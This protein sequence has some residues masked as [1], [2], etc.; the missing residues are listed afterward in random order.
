MSTAPSIDRP[1]HAW[2]LLA[3]APALALAA[4]QAAWPWPFFSDD[5]FISLRYA[6]RLLAGEGLTWT[7]G[8][9]VE[10]YSNLLWVLGCAGLGALGL[11]LVTAAR[12]LGALCTAAALWCLARA[13]G[14]RDL[15]TSLCA[16]AAPLLVAS[17][18]PVLVWT[19]GGLEGPMV[20]WLLAWG[21]G[22]VVRAL[23]VE[24]AP[25]RPA[26]LLRLGAP[27]ALLCV[28]RP[29]GAL[30]AFSTGV[31]LG[32]CALRSGWR[33]AVTRAACFGLWPLVAFGAQLAFRLAYYGDWVPNTAH[34]KAEFD[35]GGAAGL[36]Y[37]GGAM[38]VLQGLSWPALFAA[39]ALLAR[40]A[41]RCVVPVLAVPLGAWLGYLAAIG[42]DH[43][44]GLRL[45]HGALVPMALLAGAGLRT[46][47]RSAFGAAVGLAL[48][49]GGVVTNVYF[50]RTDGRSHEA[51]GELWEWRGRVLGEVLAAAFERQQPRLAVDAAGALPYYAKLPALDMLG[52]CDRTIATTPSPAWLHTVRPGTPLPPGHLRGN[53]RYVM[54]RAP[55]LMLFA[56]PPGLPLPV[57]VS[58]AEFED[59]PRFLD[60]YRCVLLELGEREVLPGRA[61]ALVSP[62]WVRIEGR[63]GVQRS[64]QRIEIPPW[65]FG[66]YALPEPLQRRHQPPTGDAAAEARRAAH[67]A[68][69]GAWYAARAAVAV[70]TDAGPLSL[71]L[72]TREPAR[73]TMQVPGGV[74]RCELQAEP[75]AVAGAPDLAAG[76]A[77]GSFVVPAPGHAV[78]LRV[79]AAAEA[80]LPVRVR[81]VVLV[82]SD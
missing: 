75:A 18:Q 59:D 47:G 67:V 50:A 79:Q 52:L 37:V 6:A 42:G 76:P 48:A 27:F 21:F 1:N 51:R 26:R 34:V 9:R 36:A 30:W 49:A 16:A 45:V 5:S 81:S 78:D 71:E 38:W 72:R 4:V 13:A 11:E 73:F 54:D 56:P 39:V 60:G 57:F 17:T 28:T 25:W 43:F 69:A 77:P 8:E 35:P 70:P 3:V 44:P 10:G 64:A 53:G 62:L 20:M 58:A 23:R 7:D 65:L 24:P 74:W 46:L 68:E 2:L 55:D 61:E 32:A 66:S 31:V 80:D 15:R 63:I 12:L 22:G 14:P 29:D 33:G 41:D 82:R 19:L 40:R